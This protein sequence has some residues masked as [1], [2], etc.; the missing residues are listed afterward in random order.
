[1]YR[2]FEQTLAVYLFYFI[3]DK[4]LVWWYSSVMGYTR[5][6]VRCK[7]NSLTCQ[8]SYIWVRKPFKLLGFTCYLLL[9]GFTQFVCF[10]KLCK[11]ARQL[12]YFLLLWSIYLISRSICSGF[13][14]KSKKLSKMSHL[15]RSW[16]SHSGK[17][18]TPQFKNEI[19]LAFKRQMKPSVINIYNT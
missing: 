11:Y 14:S 15:K 3:H 4:Y 5:R 13:K 9:F 2:Q 8:A 6:R 12:E 18:L 17:K 10:S 1:M 19:F 16:F 7:L